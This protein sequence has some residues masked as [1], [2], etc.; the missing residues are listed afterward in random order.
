MHV[1]YLS[2]LML[3]AFVEINDDV[4]GE[5]QLCKSSTVKGHY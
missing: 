4:M 3:K 1:K 5:L 2:M